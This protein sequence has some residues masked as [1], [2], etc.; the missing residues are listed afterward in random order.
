MNCVVISSNKDTVPLAAW[1][2]HWIIYLPDEIWTEIACTMLETYSTAQSKQTH[3][4]LLWKRKKGLTLWDASS[5]DTPHKRRGSYHNLSGKLLQV[6]KECWKRGSSNPSRCYYRE[7]HN[8]FAWKTPKKPPQK[9]RISAST[10][11]LTLP[12]TTPQPCSF[13]LTLPPSVSLYLPL[14]LSQ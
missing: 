7:S 9:N 14:S 10:T 5:Q 3:I 13:S 1:W 8:W 6:E 12:F 4:W 11:S 2:K